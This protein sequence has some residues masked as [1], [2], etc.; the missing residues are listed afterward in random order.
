MNHANSGPGIRWLIQIHCCMPKVHTLADTH[1]T[2]SLPSHPTKQIQLR[3][4][5]RTSSRLL[6]RTGKGR[7]QR[8]LQTRVLKQGLARRASVNL[9]LPPAQNTE[10][11][12]GIRQT[13]RQKVSGNEVT[14]V[15]NHPHAIVPFSVSNRLPE[16]FN[17]GCIFKSSS[18]TTDSI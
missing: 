14:N 9:L 2:F 11:L 1:H 3:N 12:N 16:T 15:R 8:P 7:N 13:E 5:Q 17:S 6:A 18:H 10:T 4:T